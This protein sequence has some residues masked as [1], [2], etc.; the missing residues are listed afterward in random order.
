[1]M[2]V[3]KPEGW[4]LKTIGEVAD[5]V[6][7]GKGPKYA[8]KETPLMVLNQKCVRW[9]KLDFSPARFID[10]SQISAWNSERMLKPGD[11]LWNSTGT[12]TIGR[13]CLFSS[14]ERNC[15]V[16]SHV[17][18]VRTSPSVLPKYLLYWIASPYV[19]DN[20]ESLQTGSTNQVEL[21]RKAV[22]ETPIPT[23][24]LEKQKQI[25]SRIDTLFAEID[26]G[27]EELKQAKE[28]LDLYKQS[29]L[30]AAIRGKLVPQDPNDEPA[31]KLLERIRAEKDQ[32][33]KAGK[34]KK[35]KPLPPIDPSEIPFELPKGWEWVRLGELIGIKNGYAFK[36]EY[37][38]KDKGPF[39][40]MTPGSFFEE[41][42]FRYQGARTKYYDGPV[43]DEFTLRNGDLLI[44]MTEQAPGLLGR[45][46]LVPDDGRIYLHNQ[47]LGK[48]LCTTVGPVKLF[49]Y[50]FFN[51]T[52]L[53][54]ILAQTCTGSTVRHTSP[55]RVLS[56][57]FPLPP[58]QEQDRIVKAV[59]RSITEDVDKVL[60]DISNSQSA[61]GRLKQSIL[62]IA[63]EGGLL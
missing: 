4:E 1:M 16:D 17:T 8:M 14:S 26:A 21:S 37:F 7:R 29:V 24:P 23:P 2:N 49:L 62:K 45:A 5:Y 54:N 10:R 35:E 22:L 42:G 30:N 11:V 6:Q 46:A 53:R 47:R 52:Y 55:D 20:F 31:S 25:V 19:Q 38:S 50:W 32:L 3:P 28:K 15:V 59:N 43:E 39:V 33:I 40:L 18:I 61:C 63:F 56:V 13:A 60:S 48:I 34:L 44:A 51:S 9:F 27:A 58:L 57:L 12:G 36:S 41:G